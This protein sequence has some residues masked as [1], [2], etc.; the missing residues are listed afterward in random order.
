[1]HRSINILKSY[2]IILAM[3]LFSFLI[4]IPLSFASEP[5]SYQF[6]QRMIHK[7]GSVNQSDN[8]SW[9]SHYLL[10]IR[11]FHQ[12]DKGIE[13]QFDIS[14]TQTKKTGETHVLIH[15]IKTGEL[16]WDERN[17]TLTSSDIFEN[18]PDCEDLKLGEYFYSSILRE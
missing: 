3:V 11:G 8:P 5:C 6:S 15:D 17:G 2:R 4:F 13:S 18:L 10:F 12:S 14:V 9:P 16:K 1:M 7:D